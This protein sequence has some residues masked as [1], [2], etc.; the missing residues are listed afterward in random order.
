MLQN[1]CKSIATFPTP[2]RTKVDR[3]RTLLTSSLPDMAWRLWSPEFAAKLDEWL[4]QEHFDI[5]QI[6]GIE[7]ARYG[8]QSKV[9]NLK[10]KIV[11]DDH[12]CEYLMQ[13]RWFERDIKNPERWPAAAYSFA[14]WRRLIGFE[15]AI[16]R[17]SQATLCVSP[18]D[19]ISIRHLDPAIQPHVILNGID[20][21]DYEEIGDKRLEINPQSPT[22]NF[23][24]PSLVFTGKMDFRP[25]IDAMLWFAQEAWPAV[26]QAHPSARLFIVGQKPSARLDGLRSDP[27]IVLTGEVEDI[28]PHIAPASVYIA[29]LRIGSGTRFKLLEAMAMRKAIVSTSLGCEGF[30]VAN[31]REMMIADTPSAFAQAINMLL[32]DEARCNALGHAAHQFVSSTY[33]WAAIVP[34]LEDDLRRDE[35]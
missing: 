12:N 8:F 11:F 16:I 13:Q 27:N 2:R 26:K 35:G 14:Q 4:A 17:K 29:P 18:Q 25:N 15:R 23:Q 1:A 32:S 19:K 10:S 24:S 6:E 3:L 30:E 5:I 7:L 31:G 9:Q 22:S 33:D 21:A 20:V 28:R 34:K